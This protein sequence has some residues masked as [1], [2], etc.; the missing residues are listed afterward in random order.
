M[1]VKF[2]AAIYKA[3]C[4]LVPVYPL[5]APSLHVP[6]SICPASFCPP[7]TSTCIFCPQ[8][9]YLLNLHLLAPSFHCFSS[10]QRDL[11]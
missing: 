11:P 5:A 2:L 7:D 8:N 9:A 4:N 10:P 1:E 3:S 6:H